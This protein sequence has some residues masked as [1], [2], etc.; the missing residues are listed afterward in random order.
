MDK[1]FIISKGSEPASL[2]IKNFR[3]KG[4]GT[5]DVDIQYDDEFLEHVKA[6]L[7]KKEVSNADLST[8]INTL[9]NKAVNGIEGYKIVEDAKE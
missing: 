9:V 6:D 8:Y 5:T 2:R 7:K 4:D 3:N 1:T